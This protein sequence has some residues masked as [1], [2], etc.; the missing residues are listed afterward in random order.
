MDYMLSKTI[1]KYKREYFNLFNLRV[2]FDTKIKYCLFSKIN[3]ISKFE[4]EDD[5]IFE[6]KSNQNLK[7]T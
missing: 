6:V 1:V 2:T 5:I 4:N 3:K 7:I